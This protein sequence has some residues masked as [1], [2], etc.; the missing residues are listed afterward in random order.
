[1]FDKSDGA[2]SLSLVSDGAE[3]ILINKDFF[4]KHFDS[5][6][7]ERLVRMVNENDLSLMKWQLAAVILSGSK[8]GCTSFFVLK[9]AETKF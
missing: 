4:L 3:C 6:L 8:F 1:M 7:R 5:E 2:T 9:N